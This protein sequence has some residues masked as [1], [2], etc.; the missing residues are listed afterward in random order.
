MKSFRNGLIDWKDKMAKEKK[1]KG[2]E[3]NLPEIRWMIRN[4]WAISFIYITIIY[5]KLD[6]T[7]IILMKIWIKI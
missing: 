5:K 1:K 3:I 2:K 6:K 7:Y 4:E